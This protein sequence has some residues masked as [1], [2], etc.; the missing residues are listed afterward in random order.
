MSNMNGNNSNTGKRKRTNTGKRT[1]GLSKQQQ[2]NLKIMMI[3]N[4][5]KEYKRE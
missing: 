5:V 1:D 3:K 2:I 4:M